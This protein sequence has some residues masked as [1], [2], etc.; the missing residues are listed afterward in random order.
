MIIAL[1]GCF[2][3]GKTTIVRK[4]LADHKGKPIYGALGP[5]KCEA[6]EVNLPKVKH[7]LYV[8]G[9]YSMPTGGCD[10]IQPYDLILE[11]LRK[12]TQIGHALYEGAIVSSSFGRIGELSVQLCPEVVFAFLATPLEICIERVKARRQARGNTTEFDPKNVVTKFKQVEIS[13]RSITAAARVKVVDV[14]SE[15]GAA[16]VEKLLRGA[17]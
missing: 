1:R 17:V 16:E 8:I 12:Y 11:L 14:S 4:I 10:Q 5:R 2:G 13:K 15:N 3:S 9:P 6:Y 7:P